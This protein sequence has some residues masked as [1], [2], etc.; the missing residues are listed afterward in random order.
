[1]SVPSVY[2]TIKAVIGPDGRLLRDVPL[3]KQ[4][5]PNE[6]H[7]VA[8]AE[9][10][11]AAYHFGT[12]EVDKKTL[13]AIVKLLAAY[14][15]GKKRTI[16]RLEAIVDEHKTLAIVN[17]LL[18]T[19]VSIDNR[20]TQSR[21]L[22]AGFNLAMTSA[23]V[24]LVKIGL[25]IMGLL[26]FGTVASICD[27]VAVL[28]A[29]D[30]LTLYAA[31]AARHWTGGNDLVFRMAKSVDGWGK[32]HAV[33][34]LE[35]ATDEIRDWILRH[36]CA[37]EVLNSYLG[38]ACAE[39]G[40]MIAALR[41]PDLDQELFESIGVIIDA[42]LDEGSVEGIS[43]YAHAV[44]A[45]RLYVGHAK[46]QATTVTDLRRMLSLRGWAEENHSEENQAIIEQCDSII[47]GGP[48]EARIKDAVNQHDRR[49]MGDAVDIAKKLGVDISSELMDAIRTRPLDFSYRASQMLTDPAYAPEVIEL[50]ETVLPL[51]AL[52][53]G[54]GNDQISPT[55]FNEN[56]AL[57]WMLLE[58]GHVPGQGTKLIL[59]G[60][61]SRLIRTRNATCRALEAWVESENKPLQGISPQIAAE[62]SRV[63]G[64][65]VNEKTRETMRRLI[66]PDAAI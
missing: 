29:H 1:M 30:E 33:E 50:Y 52:A 14:R 9:D 10:G 38:L 24:E 7:F 35:P 64:I 63:A 3:G 36:G 8:G 47:A 37:N 51:E 11:I 27:D 59:T 16:K 57:E 39:K 4:P 15:P 66:N 56:Q 5:K 21:I 25:S 34:R 58:L 31:E 6:L 18:K 17:Q 41:Q 49:T 44:E 61:N 48:W 40:D 60:L 46:K 19:I 20:K 26:D 65:E 62:V 54:M 28:A 43:V 22:S 2:D 13:D 12:G 42:L 32:I 45:L 53:T 23:D 55:L